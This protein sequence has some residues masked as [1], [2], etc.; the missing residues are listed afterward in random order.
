MN[1]LYDLIKIVSTADI[2]VSGVLFWIVGNIF[3]K[4]RK[5]DKSI[6][7]I[8]KDMDTINSSIKN[9]ASI[10]EM[11]LIFKNLDSKIDILLTKIENK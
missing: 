4:L 6:T 11:N 8:T 3:Y 10:N 7:S 2:F 9:Y 5:F 1:P